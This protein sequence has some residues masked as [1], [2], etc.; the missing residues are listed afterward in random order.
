LKLA[1][2][3]NKGKYDQDIKKTVAK[4]LQQSSMLTK[5]ITPYNYLK[6]YQIVAQDTKRLI[7]EGKLVE[8]DD[9]PE[10]NI[11]INNAIRNKAAS[12]F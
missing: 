2:A 12:M 10:L 9:D 11:E 3:F 6:S 4:L 1:I 7:D 8:L 5:M